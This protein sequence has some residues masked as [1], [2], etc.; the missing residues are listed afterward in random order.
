MSGKSARMSEQIDFKF[1][2]S[3]A[4]AQTSCE[5]GSQGP[6]VS[7]G[8]LF[9]LNLSTTTPAGLGRHSFGYFSVAEDRKVTRHK[10][11]TESINC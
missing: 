10:G 1:A 7:F 3:A 2:S 11:E 8:R 4:P 9:T 5:E 6:S